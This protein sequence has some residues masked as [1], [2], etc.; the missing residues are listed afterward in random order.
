MVKVYEGIE[1]NKLYSYLL[2]AI[3]FIL[4]M[5]MSVFIDYFTGLGG[6]GIILAFVIGI[7]YVVFGYY[8]SDKLVLLTTKAKKVT[9]EE[10]PYLFNVTEGLALAAGLPMPELYKIN[11]AGV[12]AY[13]TGRDPKHSA[14]VVT[15]GLLKLLNREELEGVIAHEM[16]HI[17]NYDI[18]F[19][20]LT[21]IMVGLIAILGHVAL[22]SLFF[23]RGG[24]RKGNGHIIIL[25][26]GIIF[27]ILAPIS[28][29]IVRLAISRKREYLA[30]ASGALL[31]RYPDGLAN[32][33]EKL[34]HHNT[35][36][37][38][39]NDSVAPLF[40]APPLKKSITSIFSTHPPLEERIK[41]LREM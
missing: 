14:I 32:A 31:T 26:V 20:T 28:A 24:R 18:R 7:F 21:A 8:Y 29:N 33:L 16:S 35:H 15:T 1:R 12:N 27:V 36:V 23:S 30:D 13:A 6:L 38:T 25:V 9:I 10:D 11:D 40:I 37:S 22:R 39:A 19:M 2:L 3:I 17:K 41:K 4:I 34:K 5:V